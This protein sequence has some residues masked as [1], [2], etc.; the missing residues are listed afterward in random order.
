M[1]ILESSFVGGRRFRRPATAVA[2]VGR[3]L[4]GLLCGLL[5]LVGAGSAVALEPVR[6]DGEALGRD[7]GWVAIQLLNDFEFRNIRIDRP[8]FGDTLLRPVNAPAGTVKLFRAVAGQYKPKRIELG[9]SG[10]TRYYLD[11]SPRLDFVV[12]AGVINYP[13]SIVIDDLGGL[14]YDFQ[15][16]NQHRQ[17]QS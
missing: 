8:G 13:G 5:G 16:I 9:Y 12:E 14:R 3:Y 10:N 1:Q 4:R 15:L 17:G 2:G 7:E 6:A 11:V